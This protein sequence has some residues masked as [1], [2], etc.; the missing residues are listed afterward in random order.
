MIRPAVTSLILAIIALVLIFLAGDRQR[1][2]QPLASR[3]TLT[4]LCAAGLAPVMDELKTAFELEA[5]RRVRVA[6]DYKGSAQLVALQRVG[7]TGDLLIAADTHYH[8][9]L[10]EDGLCNAPVEIA[11]QH[12]C[13]IVQP[14]TIHPESWEDALISGKFR[15]SIPKSSQAA[16]GRLVASIVGNNQYRAITNQA[17]VSRET[18]TQVAS[19]VDQGVVDVGITWNTT[20]HQFPRTC[21][22]DV[23]DWQ[24][25]RS[26]I[27]VSILSSTQDRQAAESFVKFVTGQSAR[28]I[29]K[30]HG[31]SSAQNDAVEAQ[32]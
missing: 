22:L 10:V 4:V 17:T 30:R 15:T 31:Y 11:R 3:P 23:P 25:H 27:G 21:T 9:H 12:P 2:I 1:K 5:G 19:D 26:S 16:I 6:V 8:Q 29:L 24:A 13:L 7:K 32:P 28:A 20:A 14:Q 18:V